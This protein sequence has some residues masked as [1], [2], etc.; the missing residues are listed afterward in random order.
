MTLVARDVMQPDVLTVPPALLLPELADF[1]IRHRIGGAPVV[2]G[3][4]LVGHVSRSD[5]VRAASLERSLAGVA[6]D[7]V[8][9][10]EFAPGE[11]PP[12]PLASIP[13]ELRSMT[14]R[15]VMVTDVVTVAPDTPIT[16]VAHVLVARHLHRVLV[17]DG[18]ALRGVI[19]ALDLVRLIADERAR[20]V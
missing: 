16:A 4:R 10:D 5:L 17:V 18:G 2:D 12:P 15:D 20:L 11:E 19:S 3:G 14:V 1:L 6:A 7:A 13:S 8:A 9:Q